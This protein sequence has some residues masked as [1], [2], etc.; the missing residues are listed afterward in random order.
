MDLRTAPQPD[1]DA[2]IDL[3]ARALSEGQLPTESGKHPQDVLTINPPV[4]QGRIGTAQLALGSPINADITR[5]LARDAS[6]IPIVL[7]SRGEPLDVGRA[8]RTVP[9]AI[10][11]AAILRDA[12]C[13]YP[14]CSVPA[15]IWSPIGCE[16]ASSGKL[17]RSHSLHRDGNWSSPVQHIL[18]FTGCHE[19]HAL[20]RCPSRVREVPTLYGFSAGA[21]PAVAD[22]RGLGQSGRNECATTGSAVECRTGRG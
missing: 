11:R 17:L 5:R 12:G 19:C 20:A 14:G 4:L 6:V 16:S 3:A 15:S 1:A 2:L 18:M 9:T 8:S 10:R 7:G 21:P 22:V 13:T